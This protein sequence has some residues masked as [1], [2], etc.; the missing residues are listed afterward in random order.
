M[1]IRNIHTIL[2]IFSLIKSSADEKVEEEASVD[3]PIKEPYKLG[4]FT[5]YTPGTCG[6]ATFTAN[7]M[8]GFTQSNE[9]IVPV[10]FSIVK[11]NPLPERDVLG[12][13]VIDIECFHNKTIRYEFKKMIKAIK[14]HNLNG[15]VIN[16]EYYLLGTYTFFEILFDF[17][18]DIDIP[19][20]TIAHTPVSY[21]SAE[22]KK[23]LCKIARL[24]TKILVMSW[25]AKHFLHHSYGLPKSK[26]VY[27]PHGIHKIAAS[28][29]I[30]RALGIPNNRYI[31]YCDGIIHPEKGISRMVEALNVLK[32]KN[33]L[34]NILFL[35]AGQSRSPWYMRKIVNLIERYQLQQHFL[36][37][38]RFLT[39]REMATLHKRANIYLTLFDE[40]IPTS[41]TLTYAMYSG[42]L[43]ISTPYRYAIE[44]LGIDNDP[45]TGVNTKRLKNLITE[46]KAIGYSGI[47]VPF[48]NPESLASAVLTLKKDKNL[49]NRLR[50]NSKN[51]TSGYSWK[52]VSKQLAIF[53]RTGVPPTVN[54]DP[55][56][57]TYLPSSCSWKKN[58]ISTFSS[59]KI[60]N[61]ES[62]MYLLY[63]DSF[64]AI[65]A[66]IILSHIKHIS[67]VNRKKKT[68]L[69]TKKYKR[70]Y[71]ELSKNV[72]LVKRK[73]NIF[74]ISTPNI[75]F[76]I[77]TKDKKSI[78]FN[79]LRENLHGN[80]KGVL[81]STLRQKYDLSKP[82][83]PNYKHFQIKQKI[84]PISFPLQ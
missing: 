23:H 57:K 72:K 7:M 69:S 1:N 47:C 59:T 27:F 34:G 37:I 42:D 63:S 10:V 56:V 5:T 18:K 9:N 30:L 20:Y 8:R 79:V 32:S 36:W 75:V 48:T 11:T 55:Y 41:G 76:V 13:K 39:D 52:N 54:K 46:K 17:L 6:I 84:F 35:I 40:V 24:S 38:P 4:L 60:Q 45:K 25:K 26:I 58:R 51:R 15:L 3:V 19:I 83:I 80:A 49:R 62:G 53:L 21:P 44:L 78:S 68:S 29:R 66:K 2:L 65:Y 61:V 43:I 74:Y 73:K 82:S 50:S 70:V 64:V 67:V 16:H 81:G 31:I 33:Q 22:R 12:V 28:K 71:L 14:R 77:D